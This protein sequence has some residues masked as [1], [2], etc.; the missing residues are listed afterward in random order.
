[1]ADKSS[2]LIYRLQELNTRIQPANSPEIILNILYELIELFDNNSSLQ[3]TQASILDKETHN[4]IRLNVERLKNSTASEITNTY[5]KIIAHLK[6]KVAEEAVTQ[7]LKEFEGYS[8]KTIQSSWDVLESQNL[9]LSQILRYLIKQENGD[10]RKSNHRFVRKHKL[11]LLNNEG[12]IAQFTFAPTYTSWQEEKQK[13]ENINELVECSWNTLALIY[14]TRKDPEAMLTQAANEG[15]FAEAGIKKYINQLA[16]AFNLQ[17]ANPQLHPLINIP[18]CK[19]KAQR[20]IGYTCDILLSEDNQLVRDAVKNYNITFD[21][22]SRTFTCNEKQHRFKKNCS[23]PIILSM[24]ITKEGPIKNKILEAEDAHS[25]IMKTHN[26]NENAPDIYEI[27]RYI[28]KC[29]GTKIGL[30]EF[31]II[32]DDTIQIDPKYLT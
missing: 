32:I 30:T 26:D 19:N 23:S 28:N 8:N 18:G 25:L 14:K 12:D 5:E 24:L 20:I 1:M 11:A 13:F 27:G 7:L 21:K 31:L 16:V 29:I 17:G 3:P 6:G 22:S 2:Q 9:I 15:I 4:K 10:R